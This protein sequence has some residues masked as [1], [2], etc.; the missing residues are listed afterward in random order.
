VRRPVEGA[1][2]ARPS[3]LVSLEIGARS[4]GRVGGRAGVGR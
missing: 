4:R 2:L 3:G 1:R